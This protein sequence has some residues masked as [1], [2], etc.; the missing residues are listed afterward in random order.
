MKFRSPCAFLLC[1]YAALNSQL[2]SK[3]AFPPSH[4]TAIRRP[5]CRSLSLFE[6]GPMSEHRNPDPQIADLLELLNAAESFQEIEELLKQSS[7]RP[8]TS[9]M[10]VEGENRFAATVVSIMSKGTR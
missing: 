2:R 8:E 1:K 9:I 4:S 6:L 5:K 10:P 7:R 3:D